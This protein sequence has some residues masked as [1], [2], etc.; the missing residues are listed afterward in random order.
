MDRMRKRGGKRI[1]WRR[2]MKVE[3]EPKEKQFHVE[4]YCSGID[5]K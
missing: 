2:T 3:Q 5:W 1:S 4:V